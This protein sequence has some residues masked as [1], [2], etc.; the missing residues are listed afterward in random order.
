MVLRSVLLIWGPVSPCFQLQCQRTDS[1]QCQPKRIL[2][3]LKKMLSRLHVKWCW[4][5]GNKPRWPQASPG[6]LPHSSL[7]S[8]SVASLFS[9]LPRGKCSKWSLSLQR[10]P[11]AG[12]WVPLAVNMKDSL[13]SSGVRP[14]GS[15]HTGPSLTSSKECS[16][17]KSAI[18]DIIESPSLG[19]AGKTVYFYSVVKD[20]A[21]KSYHH[22]Y[23]YYLRIYTTTTT[24]SLEHFF[25]FWNW[26]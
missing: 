3:S 9:V 7:G 25:I 26:N 18:R 24:V 17:V 13:H 12:R 19:S 10:G 15:Q 5:M 22:E 11:H 21:H 16:N 23:F 20:S 8:W 6:H 2:L 14:A 1:L 4:F